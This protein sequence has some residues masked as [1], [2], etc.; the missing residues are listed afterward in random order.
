V[1]SDGADPHARTRPNSEPVSDQP[2]SVCPA[3]REFL[4]GDNDELTN[5]LRLS[6]FRAGD[7]G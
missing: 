2:R 3:L 1:L 6:R 4:H 7:K 5:D